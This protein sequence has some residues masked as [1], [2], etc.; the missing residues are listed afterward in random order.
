[1]PC[2][3]LVIVDISVPRSGSGPKESGSESDQTRTR[4]TNFADLRTRTGTELHCPNLNPD[5]NMTDSSVRVKFGVHKLVRVRW[6]N[7]V[8]I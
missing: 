2:S 3:Y 8:D 7:P 1:M 5:S 6:G 4:T